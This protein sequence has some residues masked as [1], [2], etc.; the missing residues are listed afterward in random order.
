MMTPTGRFKTDTR[1][2]LSMS[3]YHPETWSSSWQIRTV[4]LG[5]LSF[6]FVGVPRCPPP[7]TDLLLPEKIH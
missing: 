7:A 6:M 1:L 5:L 3:D 4:V 2:C